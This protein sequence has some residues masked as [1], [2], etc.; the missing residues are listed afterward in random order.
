MVRK[1]PE[2]VAGQVRF[3]DFPGKLQHVVNEN[4]ALEGKISTLTKDLSNEKKNCEYWQTSFKNLKVS[5]D[6]LEK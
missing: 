5:A 4:K 6:C 3:S 1:V 2:P